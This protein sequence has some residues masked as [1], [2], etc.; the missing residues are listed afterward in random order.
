MKPDT[1]TARLK[2]LVAPQTHTIEIS[3]IALVMLWL[4]VALSVFL[5][6]AAC[7]AQF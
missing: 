6:G 4:N 7:G 1:D 2:R 5:L 3:H